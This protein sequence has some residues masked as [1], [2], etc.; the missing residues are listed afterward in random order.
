MY[1]KKINEIEYLPFFIIYEGYPNEGKYIYT[2]DKKYMTCDFEYRSQIFRHT[3][4][5]VWHKRYLCFGSLV[6][7]Y[8]NDK[9]KT[10][11]KENIELIEKI[12][13]I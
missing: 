11:V 9:G 1:Y 7:I 12:G 10:L 6:N 4:L 13:F 5:Y 3:N 8:F 2:V